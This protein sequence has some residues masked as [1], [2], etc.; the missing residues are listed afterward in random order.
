[1]RLLHQTMLILKVS[2]HFKATMKYS[3]P[4]LS[5]SDA[6]VGLFWRTFHANIGKIKCLAVWFIVK[7]VVVKTLRATLVISTQCERP[8]TAIFDASVGQIRV[9]LTLTPSSGT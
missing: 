7:N 1:M 3:T 6:C 4:L 8:L 5:G 2:G 9:P